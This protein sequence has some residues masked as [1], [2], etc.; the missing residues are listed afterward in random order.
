MVAASRLSFERGDRQPAGGRCVGLSVRGPRHD[1]D[2][3]D[4]PEAPVA[5]EDIDDKFRQVV[6]SC[7]DPAGIQRVIELVRGMEDFHDIG[8]LIAI[9]AAAPSK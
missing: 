6:K 5:P 3:D 7:L 2:E 4:V 1:I 9:M 8:E